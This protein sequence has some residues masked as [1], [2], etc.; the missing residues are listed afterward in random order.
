[1]HAGLLSAPI[2]VLEETWKILGKKFR[3]L[4]P[5]QL[6]LSHLAISSFVSL[7]SK[8]AA[9]DVQMQPNKNP[10]S[11]CSLESSGQIYHTRVATTATNSYHCH[12]QHSRLITFLVRLYRKSARLMWT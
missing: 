12:Q 6:P 4:M 5:L 1:M 3:S 7:V 10:K 2:L 11:W 9:L 8:L